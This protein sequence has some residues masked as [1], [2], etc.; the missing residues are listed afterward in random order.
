MLS[1]LVAVVVFLTLSALRHPSEYGVIPP[2]PF[3]AGTGFYCPGCGSLRATHYLVTG[4]PGTSL[5]YNPLVASV[6]PLLVFSAIRRIGEV[7]AGKVLPF[8]C[9][10]GVY[11]TVLIVFLVFFVSRNIPLE[12]FD[13]LRPPAA[14]TR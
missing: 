12:L 1:G 2:C 4:R 8:P 5:R 13:V 10:S 7:F 3:R 6:L 9:Q 11:W 14:G